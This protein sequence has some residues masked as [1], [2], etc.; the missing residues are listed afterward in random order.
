V[1]RPFGETISAI[2]EKLDTIE[3]EATRITA[4]GHSIPGTEHSSAILKAAGVIWEESL[5]I[6]EDL[7]A[8]QKTE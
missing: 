3:Q 5:L 1:K 8:L 2:H 6:R 7:A 4:L